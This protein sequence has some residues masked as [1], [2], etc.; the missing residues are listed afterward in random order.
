MNTYD[1]LCKRYDELSGKRIECVLELERAPKGSIQKKHIS[2]R[3]YAYLQYR[4][5]RSVRSTYISQDSLPA[6][7]AQ[8]KKRNEQKNNLKKIDEELLAIEKALKSSY[9]KNI[10]RF[11][12]EQHTDE[13]Y[14]LASIK[15]LLAP[16]FR[17]YDIKKAIV[18]GSYAKGS[19]SAQSDIDIV[20]ASTLHGLDFV[21]FI[22]DIKKC[23]GKE[24]DIIDVSHIDKNSKIDREI[25]KTGVVLYA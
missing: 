5:G 16:I 6:L 20:V 18:F 9:R 25:Q 2:G 4:D 12:L 19:A 1:F 3:L 7:E 14:S 17:H 15:I 13:V 22:S 24:A 21:E 23:L 8:L 10:K 11:T